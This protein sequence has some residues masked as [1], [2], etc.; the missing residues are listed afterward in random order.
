M[1]IDDRIIVFNK[2]YFAYL[3]KFL[4]NKRHIDT[5]IIAVAILLRYVQNCRYSYQ[6]C[7]QKNKSIICRDQVRICVG[8]TRAAALHSLVLAIRFHPV[9][10]QS[11]CLFI[12]AVD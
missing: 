2:I 9:P 4:Q 6:T 3:Q 10:T 11:Q 12:Q 7:E 8:L 5:V 1:N